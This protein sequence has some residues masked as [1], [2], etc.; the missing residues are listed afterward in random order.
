M[1]RLRQAFETDIYNISVDAQNIYEVDRKLYNLLTFYPA[2]VLI[3]FDKVLNEIYRSEILSEDAA[4]AFENNILT[5]CTNLKFKSR[6]RELNPKDINHLISI[7]GIIIK[8]SEIYPDMKDAHFKCTRCSHVVNSMVDRGKLSEP[9]VCP[10]CNARQSFELIHNLC[11]FT[12]KQFVKMQETPE[13]VPEGETP[14]NVNLILYDDM[15]DCVKPGDRVEITG[16]YRAQPSRMTRGKRILLSVF[17]TYIDVIS[18]M[19]TNKSK[20]SIRHEDDEQNAEDNVQFTPEEESRI[21]ELSKDRNLYKKLEAALAP[22]IWE[23]EDVKKGILCQLFA[24]TKKDFTKGARA[25]FRNDINILLVGDPSVAKSQLLQFVHKIV[26]RGIYTSG[27]GSSAVGLTAYITKDPETRE[28][29]LESGALVLSD[30]GICCIDEFDKM[31]DDTKTILHEVMEQQ[32]ISIAKNGIVCSLNART[33]ILAAANPKDS[34]YNMAKSLVYNIQLPPTLM[35]RFD[36]IYLM[37]DRPNERS[38]RK[39]AEHLLSLYAPSTMTTANPF[40][41]STISRELFAKYITFS[42]K[43]CNPEI[44]EDVTELLIDAYLQMRNKGRGASRTTITATPRQLESLIRISEALAKMRLS[45][46]VE[47]A[48]VREASR[49][50]EVAIAQSSINP[51]TGLI[52][53]DQL[54]TGF[55]E[56]D[57]EKINTI[58]PDIIN[59]LIVNFPNVVE[60]ERRSLQERYQRLQSEG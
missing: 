42:R 58:I 46:R 20:H 52:D 36:L 27:K 32:T 21:R 56:Q 34:R 60:K 40:G 12:D 29:V 7:Q 39:L 1:G 6:M 4:L 24:G 38:D 47:A 51:V 23:N 59:A 3:M 8:T 53:M 19:S 57:R 26:P 43:Y 50:I 31:T 44:P 13:T 41:T 22:S 16:I 37:L 49:L 18:S 45:D 30:K 9:M 54:N 28:I 25:K 5:R 10:R 35:S 33:A 48:D 11:N 15:V 55:A 14:Q 17:K 2:E